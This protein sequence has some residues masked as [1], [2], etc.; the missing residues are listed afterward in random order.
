[1][2]HV[3]ASGGTTKADIVCAGLGPR[4]RLGK[5]SENDTPQG[6]GRHQN[7]VACGAGAVTAASGFKYEK[8]ARAFKFFFESMAHAPHS[9]C[10]ASGGAHCN[11][12]GV[13]PG[14]HRHGTARAR[15]YRS[16]VTV[17]NYE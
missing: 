9:I 16:T 1:M 17:T 2:D 15:R 5:G 13:R 4:T 7:K 14:C 8:E 12:R 11:G 6:K 10:P 3:A